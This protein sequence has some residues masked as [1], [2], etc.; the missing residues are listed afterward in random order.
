MC[1]WSSREQ[2]QGK[3]LQF[4]YEKKKKSYF[5]FTE[6]NKKLLR[7]FHACL[8]VIHFCSQTLRF[9]VIIRRSTTK[10]VLVFQLHPW[11]PPTKGRVNKFLLPLILQKDCFTLL[12][13]K[14]HFHILRHY[15][16]PAI[17]TVSVGRNSK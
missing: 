8:L 2:S 10:H 5:D 1:Y 7:E 9:I 6:L 4:L 3:T 14:I 15:M 17:I 12:L 11:L 13:F 16:W